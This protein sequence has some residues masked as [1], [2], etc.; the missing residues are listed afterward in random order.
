MVK[1]KHPVSMNLDLSHL[2]KVVKAMSSNTAPSNAVPSA[3][4]SSP[5]M[6]AASATKS[7]A[8]K[9]SEE[10]VKARI[11]KSI[12]E[13]IEVATGQINH[14]LIKY[15]LVERVRQAINAK[16][17]DRISPADIDRF[18]KDAATRTAYSLSDIKIIPSEFQIIIP[19]DLAKG[20]KLI[21]TEE[22]AENH[23]FD[24]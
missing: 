3:E 20:T 11:E 7:P 19:V 6:E 8:K 1:K 5:A 2:S 21:H 24:D 13:A 18:S 14:K 4:V 17:H 15:I 10:Q 12:N 23:A 22:P 9:T 16:F